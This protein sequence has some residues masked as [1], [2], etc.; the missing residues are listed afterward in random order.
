MI[1]KISNIQANFR[2]QASQNTTQP[3][4]EAAYISQAKCFVPG[5]KQIESR[6]MI[7]RARLGAYAEKS[8]LSH[9]L[10]LVDDGRY[11]FSERTSTPKRESERFLYFC[12]NR[13]KTKIKLH[14]SSEGSNPCF[15][16][17]RGKDAIQFISE[18]TDSMPIRDLFETIFDT[19]KSRS[20]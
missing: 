14:P 20:N 7:Q 4:F 19:L 16:Y 11:L 18:P 10:K 12:D 15:I 8:L 17:S 9:L 3:S 1:N 6:R 5:L 13:T 2:Q